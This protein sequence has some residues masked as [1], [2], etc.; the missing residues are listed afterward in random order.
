M[1]MRLWVLAAIPLVLAGLLAAEYAAVPAPE[2]TR[3][4]LAALQRELRFTYHECVPLGWAPVPVR[5]TYYPGY[6]A[7]AATYEDM[8]DAVWRGSINYADLHNAQAFEVYSMLEHLRAQGLLTR[9]DARSGYRYFLSPGALPYYYGSSVFKD[10]RDSLPYLCYS[11][12]VPTHIGWM[13]KIAATRGAVTGQW[14][15]L[16]FSWKPSSVPRWAN[17][18][19]IRSHSVLLAPLASPTTAR[20]VF[21]DDDWQLANVYDRGWMLPALKRSAERSEN[22]TALPRTRP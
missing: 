1:V 2:S 17:D 10:N 18:P 3:G 8:L 5:G 20:V 11:R 12:I 6:T 15:T 16:Q 7:S 4:V 13:R 14:Y 19:Y 21:R 9:T 22:V